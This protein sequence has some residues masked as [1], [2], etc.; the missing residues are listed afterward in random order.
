MDFPQEKQVKSGIVALVGPP[1]VGKSTLLNALLGQKISIVS[2]KPQTTRNRILGIVNGADHQIV[3][4]DTPGIH[5]ARSPLNQ[6]MVRIA[7]ESLIEVDVIVFMI[8]TTFPVPA[9]VGNAAAHLAAAGRPAILLINK[10]DLVAPETLLPILDAYKNLYPFAAMIPISAQR[11][12][13]TDILLGELLRLLPEGPRLY[14]EDIPTDAT[15][16]FIAAEL[17]REKIFLHTTKEVPYSCAVTVDSFREETRKIV[18][19]ATIY[20]EK[21]SQK[22]I[23]IGKGGAMLKKIGR[24]ARL[25]LQELL[26]VPVTLQLWVKVQKDWTR[27]AR[28]L[29]QLG[30]GE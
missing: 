15:E 8:D 2:P 27:D 13:G 28:F 21:N 14:P 23:I 7:V 22:G 4:L 29:R 26:G 24:S 5:E 18:I 16:R 19:D 12:D 6:E 30:L 10:T 9:R 20:V 1:N 17:I 3:L 11:G 25:D